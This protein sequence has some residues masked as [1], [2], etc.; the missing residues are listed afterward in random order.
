MSHYSQHGIFVRNKDFRNLIK[1]YRDNFPNDINLIQIYT[2]LFE[3]DLKSNFIIAYSLTGR[4]GFF[5]TDVKV[6]N[7]RYIT[8]ESADEKSEFIKTLI[9]LIDKINIGLD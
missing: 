5:S 6:D 7:G 2:E 8:W 9:D 3:Q 4:L 1:K